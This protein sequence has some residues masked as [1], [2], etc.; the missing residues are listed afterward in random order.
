[1]TDPDGVMEIKLGDKLLGTGPVLASANVAAGPETQLSLP[2]FVVAVALQV[3]IMP[4]RAGDTSANAP[5]TLWAFCLQAP[6]ALTFLLS[7]HRQ[8]CS[9]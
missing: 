3:N 7:Q 4:Q 9:E 6:A 1:M 5:A 2:A 8:C